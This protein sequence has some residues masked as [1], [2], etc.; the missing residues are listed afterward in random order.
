MTL[1]FYR[2]LGHV[3]HVIC[4]DHWSL[5]VFPRIHTCHARWYVFGI[6]VQSLSRSWAVASEAGRWKKNCRVMKCDA[7]FNVMWCQAFL[8]WTGWT[9]QLALAFHWR[10]P[11]KNVPTTLRTRCSGGLSRLA[12]Q[13]LCRFQGLSGID[14]VRVTSLL[15]Q[16]KWHV[17]LRHCS[18][19]V[20]RSAL[21][22]V[23]IVPLRSLSF[24]RISTSVKCSTRWRMKLCNYVTMTWVDWDGSLRTWKKH[25][26]QKADFRQD[27]FLSPCKVAEE[28]WD[29]QRFFPTKARVRLMLWL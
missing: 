7:K 29:P 12:E 3:G 10:S 28:E 2:I 1:N 14:Q 21:L 22:K 25:P 26:W 15:I 13:S 17:R 20:V 16:M 9:H 23:P 5:S 19:T 4:H 18:Y 6:K 24:C 8:F 11:G 27:A